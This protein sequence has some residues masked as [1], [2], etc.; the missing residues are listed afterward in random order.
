MSSESILT[1]PAPP[2]DAHIAYGSDSNQFGELRIPKSAGPFPIVINFHGGF[3]RAKYDLAHAGHL[4]AAL[5]AKGLA[6]WNVEY[7]RVGNKGGGWPGTFEDVRNSYRYVP[8][9]AQKYNLDLAKMLVMGHSAGGQL[10]LCL[11]SHEPA[12]KSVISLAG[13]ADLQQAW[14]LHLSN[15]A[16][17]EFLGGTPKEVPEHYH[18]ADPMQLKVNATQWLIHGAGDD[19]VPS[20]M[21]RG[22]VQ[23]KKVRGEDAH[24]LEI[25]AAGHYELIDP[26]SSAYSKIESTILHLLNS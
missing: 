17:G 24:L 12:V 26:H 7:R 5:T 19:V 23:A 3:W 11:A 6:T 21:S 10:A 1:Q 25:A 14:E 20:T 8:Q 13:V 9:I 2:A 4:C 15:N 22:Y 16:V 18:E